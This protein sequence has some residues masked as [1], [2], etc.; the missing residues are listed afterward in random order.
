[1]VEGECRRGAGREEE[2]M[3]GVKYEVGY[4]GRLGSAD[5]FGTMDVND[6][7]TEF[8]ANTGACRYKLSKTTGVL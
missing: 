2:R 6:F 1:M 7:W 3:N 8:F 4:G 5:I